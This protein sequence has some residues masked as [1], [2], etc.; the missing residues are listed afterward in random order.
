MN[1]YATFRGL[2][3]AAERGRL[4][5]L[6]FDMNEL[7]EEVYRLALAHVRYVERVG[8]P[9]API[10]ALLGHANAALDD[11]HALCRHRRIRLG[12]AKAFVIDALQR[13]LAAAAGA[14]HGAAAEL[15]QA[16][17]RSTVLGRRIQ[18]AATL[19]GDG[20]MVRWSQQWLRARRTL[21]ED[22]YLEGAFATDDFLLQARFG[23]AAE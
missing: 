21:I 20:E 15:S 18:Q 12:S 4:A 17:G 10:R 14:A 23:M 13:L 19:A 1:T 11:L 22:A 8:G 9:S 2:D 16:L 5:A 3:R 7:E 6:L